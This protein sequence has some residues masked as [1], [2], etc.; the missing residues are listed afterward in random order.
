MLAKVD[1]RVAER[2][3]MVGEQRL[4]YAGTDKFIRGAIN[5]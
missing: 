1:A 4:K 2:D 5:R 3:R